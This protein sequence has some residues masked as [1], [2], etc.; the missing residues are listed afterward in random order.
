MNSYIDMHCDTLQRTF[1]QG[2]SSLYDGEGMQSIKLMQEAKQMCQFFAVFF[3]PRDVP[4]ADGTLR[5]AMPSDE[6]FFAIL[7]EN[8]RKEVA[9]HRDVIAMAENATDIM[10]NWSKGLS[11][12]VLTVEDG[13]MV[14]G[15]MDRLLFLYEHGIMRTVSDIPTQRNPK[16]CPKD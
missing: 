14:Q 10:N 5:P 1:T 3:P 12:A 8:L 16:S 15:R 6:E 11:S 13:R 9:M 2:A 4:Y 7:A